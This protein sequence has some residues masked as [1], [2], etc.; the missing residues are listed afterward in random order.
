MPFGSAVVEGN[1][2]GLITLSLLM[3]L[4]QGTIRT[5]RKIRKSNSPKVVIREACHILQEA[6]SISSSRPG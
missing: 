5:E 4:V 3:R 6:P 2:C 1:S